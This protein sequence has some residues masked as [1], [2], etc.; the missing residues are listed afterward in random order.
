[1]STT[2]RSR[3]KQKKISLFL[4]LTMWLLAAIFFFYEFLLQNSTSVMLKPLSSTFGI[5]ATKFGLLSTFYFLAYS[6]VQLPA[7][8]L[9]DRF[10]PRKL[11]TIAAG[12]CGVGTVIMA[13]AQ[14]FA[15]I[16][17]ARFVTGL[18]SG[19]A[20]L[21]A[22]IITANWFSSK[23]FAL[24][25]GL[26]LTIGITGAAF[27][28]A[29]LG[30]ALERY[31][32]R[33][34]ML[35]LG[36][37]GITLMLIM[38][39]VIRDR[40][41]GMK[42]A[43]N[44]HGEEI[45]LRDLLIGSKKILSSRQ[46][47]LTAAYGALMYAP[48][49][50]LMYWLQ[51]YMPALRGFSVE[52]SVWLVSIMYLGWIFGSPFFGSISDFIGRRKVTLYISTITTLTLIIFI[53]YVPNLSYLTYNFLLFLFGFFT[54]GFV[55]SFS[56]VRE[57][58]RSEYSGSAL[59]FMNMVNSLGP[60][61]APLIVGKLLDLLWSGHLTDNQRLYSVSEYKIALLVCPACLLLALAILPFIKE[62]YCKTIDHKAVS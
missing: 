30:L 4:P 60:A 48:T 31:G 35:I 22:L 53:L 39:F 51:S 44:K 13:S 50:A 42:R 25:H 49:A 56:I 3:I 45:N 10:G 24:M 47:W 11:L 1:M 7:G 62:T 34:A 26:T 5:S 43:R 17:I 61:L 38:F 32:W 29:P 2:T 41:P 12:V 18:G 6:S 19:F 23:R 40:P 28:A 27:G 54:T 9:L 36:V 57:Q 37:F 58:H 15:Y 55:P 33:H 21:G 52:K 16:E 8:L 59:G 20:M 14:N 46:T